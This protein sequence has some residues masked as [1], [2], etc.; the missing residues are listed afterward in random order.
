MNDKQKEVAFLSVQILNGVLSDH[1]LYD[2][3]TY[4]AKNGTLREA[5][6]IS[7]SLANDLVDHIK[8]VVE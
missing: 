6:M 1:R 5:M 4:P 3:L 2:T 8:K 7:V